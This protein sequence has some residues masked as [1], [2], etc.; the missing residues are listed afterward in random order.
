MI[1]K[2]WGTTDPVSIT[3]TGTITI[4]DD[5]SAAIT[6]A[7]VSVS[8]DA[9]T[10][11]VTATLDKATSGGFSLDLATIDGSA[12]TSDNDY[13]SLIAQLVSFSGNPS[14]NQTVSIT[15]NDDLKV[16]DK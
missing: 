5:D 14:E 9:G 7:D 10:A 15:L 13:S 3:D 12:T 11:T 6:I 1:S 16:E 8:E 2:L 4:K